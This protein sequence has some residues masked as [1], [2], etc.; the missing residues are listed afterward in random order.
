MYVRNVLI[1][2]LLDTLL[3]KSM[4]LGIRAEYGNLQSSFPYSVQLLENTDQKFSMCDSLRDLVSFVKIKK[5]EKHIHGGV[6]LLV[7][8]QTSLLKITLLHG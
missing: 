6:L 4:K 3:K 7:K 5:R 2:Q 1:Y 8:L